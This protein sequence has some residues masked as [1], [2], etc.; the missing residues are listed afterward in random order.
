MTLKE[1]K[2]GLREEIQELKDV[3]KRLKNEQ[4]GIDRYS[5]QFTQTGKYQMKVEAEVQLEATIRIY[6]NLVLVRKLK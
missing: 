5:G 3:L 2:E 4:C 1:I 6:K